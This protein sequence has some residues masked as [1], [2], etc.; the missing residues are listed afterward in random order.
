VRSLKS[1][2][3]FIETNVDAPDANFFTK[4]LTVRPLNLTLGGTI[5]K[6]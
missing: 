6:E 4:G 5:S 2:S 3:Y 1:A